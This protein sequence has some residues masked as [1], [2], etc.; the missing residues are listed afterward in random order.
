MPDL[1]PPIA[2]PEDLSVAIE[3]AVSDPSIRWYVIK[4]ADALRQLDQIPMEWDL[5][6]SLIAASRVF[7]AESRRNYAKQGI[8]LSDGS[9]PIPDRDALRRAI[10]RLN[11]TT[12]DKSLVRRHIIKRARALGALGMLPDAWKAK[13]A[14]TDGSEDVVTVDELQAEMMRLQMGQLSG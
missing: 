5:S 12:K 7:S 6:E 14:S 1:I 3:A 2:T 13:T 10:I 8:A 11:S 4:K 9:F